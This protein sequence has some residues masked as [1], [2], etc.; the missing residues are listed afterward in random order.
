[1]ESQ[2]NSPTLLYVEDDKSLAFVTRDNL[3]QFGYKVIHFEN[4]QTALSNLTS[5]KFDLCLLDIMMPKMDGFELAKRI[6]EIN[7]DVPILFLSA[8]AGVDDRI[9]GFKLGAD[10]YL[11]KPFSMEELRLKIEVFLKR[12][13]VWNQSKNMSNQLKIGNS[14]L[15]YQNQLLYSGAVQ[16]KLTLRETLLLEHLFSHANQIVKREDIL[17]R[18]WG[19][20]SYFNGRSLDVFVSRIRKYLSGDTSIEIE[21]IRSIGF[22]LHQT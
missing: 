3:Q 1:M 4:G 9:Q 12:N 22:R 16:T 15:D 20:D 19:D 2:A 21:N 10:D 7:H 17:M 5:Y 11:T 8:K 18:I 6:R 13:R 14:I